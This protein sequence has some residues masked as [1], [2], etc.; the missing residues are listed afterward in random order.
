VGAMEGNFLQAMYLTLPAASDR[1]DTSKERPDLPSP[2]ISQLLQKV[3]HTTEHDFWRSLIWI[4]QRTS[5]P[6]RKAILFRPKVR[7][8]KQERQLD[9]Y[10]R[11]LSSNTEVLI[12]DENLQELCSS[13]ADLRSPQRFPCL[14]IR[15]TTL[16]GIKPLLH[17]PQ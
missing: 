10:L 1:C 14:C 6:E 12:A 16:R 7:C 9:R 5:Q 3:Y 11:I 8:W 15:P 13:Q 17:P 4:Q 2:P